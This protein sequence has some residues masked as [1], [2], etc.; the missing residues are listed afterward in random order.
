MSRASSAGSVAGA[1]VSG[2]VLGLV[3]GA[4]LLL[5]LAAILLVTAAKMWRHR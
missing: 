5:L 3:P 4:V 1:F 2:Q